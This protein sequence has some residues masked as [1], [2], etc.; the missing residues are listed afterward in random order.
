MN[1]KK[2]K[3]KKDKKL[4]EKPKPI[5]RPK[6]HVTE[7]ERKKAR[8]ESNQKFRKEGRDARKKKYSEDEQYRAKVLE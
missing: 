4:V 8:L 7:E 1:K 6:L 3:D 5:G 2:G